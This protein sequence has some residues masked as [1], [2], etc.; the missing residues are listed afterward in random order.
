MRTAFVQRARPLALVAILMLV[1]SACGGG[2]PSGSLQAAATPKPTPNPH[3]KDPATADQVFIELGKAGLHITATNA[4]SGSNGEEP[5]KRINATYLGWPLII[6]QYSSSS[7]LRKVFQW[8]AGDPPRQGEPPINLTGMNIL[9]TWGPTT[10][11]SPKKPDDAKRNALDSI[12]EVLDALLSPLQARTIVP[13]PVA[14]STPAPPPTA[15]P[16]PIATPKP[17]KAPKPSG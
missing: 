9:V 7:A 10:G 8:K 15:T 16:K 11:A 12:I 14:G 2:S 13:V 5:V 1:A 6:S 3:L 17:S 4:A